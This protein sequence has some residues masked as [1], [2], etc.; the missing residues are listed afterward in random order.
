MSSMIF[1]QEHTIRV[2]DFKSN[3]TIPYAHVC[4]EELESDSKYYMVTTKDGVANIPGNR[5]LIVAVSFVGY[6]AYIDTIKPGKDYTIELYPKVFDIDQVVVTANFT[7]QKADQSI[8][9]VKVIDRRDIDMK[10]ATNLSDIMANVVNVKLKHDPALGT[11]LRLKGLSGNNVKILIDGVPIIGRVGGNIDLSQLNLYN[12]D[13]IELVEGPLSVIYG[14]N[15]LAGAINIITKENEYSKLTA[16]ANTYYESVGTYNVDGGIS[17]KHGKHSFALSGGRNFFGGFSDQDDIIVGNNVVEDRYSEWKPKEQYNADLYYTLNN[18]RNKL[19]YQSSFMRER[20]QSKGSLQSP[21]YYTAFDDW[22]Y[23]TRF[24]NRLE[25]TQKIGAEYTLNMLGSHSYY[26]RRNTTYFMDLDQLTST[27]TNEDTTKFNAFVYRLLIGNSNPEKK[28]S[29]VTGIDLNY[30]M[31]TGEKILDNEKE[32]GDYAVF[33]SVMYKFNEQISVQPGIRLA[34]N[35]QYDVPPVPSINVKWNI[36]PR[37]TAR[38][39]YA[40]GYRAPSLKELY[41]YFVDI[42]HNIQPNENLKAEHGNNF[43]F[44]L[45]FNTD[46]DKKLHYSQ[47]ELGAFYNDMSNI[48]YLAKRQL[49]DEKDPIY[50]YINIVNYNTIGG[51]VSFQY[52]YYPYMNFAVSFGETGTYSSFNGSKNSLSDYKFSPDLNVNVTNQIQKLGLSITL[53]YKYTGKSYLYD[54]DENDQI[55]LTTLADY[56]NMDLTFIRKFFTNRLTITAGVKNLFDNTSI[57]VIGG[58]TGTA[59]TSGDS[60]PIGYGRIYFARLSYNIFK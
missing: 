37:L 32:L 53:S 6:K 47:V 2:V 7:P 24:T 35:S 39:S 40:R 49:P 10:A 9:N 60:S 26:Q 50:Q 14:S 54:V 31:A 51:Q 12:I 58:G 4:F 48:I 1:G 20:L 13:H 45:K 57:D 16:R 15:A 27:L 52:N 59:H 18:K 29:F 38:A 21:Q 43:D 36:L 46:R 19:K 28:L 22:F 56:H 23:S 8:Y 55:S 44:A 5:E 11:S 25:F 17:S 3:E 34:Y 33:T 30:E 42:N 41:I